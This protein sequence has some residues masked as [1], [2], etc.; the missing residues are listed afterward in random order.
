M[1]NFLTDGCATLRYG[2]GQ[3]AGFSVFWHGLPL[4]TLI[5]IMVV[6][7]QWHLVKH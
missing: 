5:Q 2:G 7:H 6:Y 1:A 4:A 3:Y